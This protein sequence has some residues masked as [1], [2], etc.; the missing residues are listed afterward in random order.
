MKIGLFGGSFDP[1]HAGHL[2]PVQ[3]A[4]QELGLEKVIYLPTARPPHKQDR[5]LVAPQARYVMVELALLEEEGLYA[6]PFEMQQDRPAYTYETL[7]HFHRTL[8]GTEFMLFVGGDSLVHLMS[9]R[10]WQRI[11]ELAS[12]VVMARPGWNTEALP[13][14]LGQALDG[15]LH[16]V[17]NP[18]LDIS[19]TAVREAFFRGESPPEGSIKPMVLDYIHKYRLYQ[20][21]TPT[22]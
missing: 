22:P 1:I 19:S 13:E 21:K 20:E 4:R 18:P 12:I 17:A 15:R 2:A 10:N 7:E 6:S 5:E 8:P 11:L 16:T 14:E 3:H 9:W